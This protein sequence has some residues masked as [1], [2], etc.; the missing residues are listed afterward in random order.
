M[1]EDIAVVCERGRLM[2]RDE[3]LVTEARSMGGPWVDRGAVDE[4]P[5]KAE[6]HVI[7]MRIA[8]MPVTNRTRHMGS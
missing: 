6:K 3:G 7:V 4:C 1:E 2:R 8:L 5:F